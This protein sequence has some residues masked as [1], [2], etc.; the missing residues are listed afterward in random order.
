MSRNVSLTQMCPFME[1]NN[2]YGHI[3]VGVENIDM[4]IGTLT[5]GEACINAL[6]GSEKASIEKVASDLEACGKGSAIRR[7]EAH[8]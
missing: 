4:C 6:V 2:Y 3:N 5:S 8:W 1:W 7:S